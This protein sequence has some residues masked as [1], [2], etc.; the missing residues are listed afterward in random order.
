LLGAL[1]LAAAMPGFALADP[2][3]A[4]EGA[5]GFG[6]QTRGGDGG[7]VLYVT[8]LDDDAKKPARGSLRWAVEHDGPRIVRFKVAGNIRL[9]APL[10]VREP[11]LT[12][13]GS[14]APGPV[15][16][17]DYGLSLGDTHDVIVR[18]L[19]LRRGDRATLKDVKAKGLDRPK[20]SAGLDTASA[21]R[22]RNILFDHCSLSWSCDEVFGIVGC[23][24]VTIQWCIISGP[25]SNPRLHPYGDN[26]AFGLNLSANTLSL[27]H[28]LIAHYVMRGPQFEC[29]DVRK[30]QGYDVRMEAVNNVMFDYERSGS[31]YTTGIENNPEDAE[32]T[33]FEF[34]FINNYYV[35]G[36]AKKPMIEAVTRHGVIDDLRVYI[37]GNIG[38]QRKTDDLDQLRGVYIDKDTTID[39][40]DRAIR[41]QLV[42]RP[43]FA[44][45]VPVTI[46]PAATAYE[47][48]LA[49]AGCGGERDAVDARVLED[50]AKRRFGRIV[51]SQDDVG[52]WPEAK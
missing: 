49:E 36:D 22:S 10:E 30:G 44:A 35:N 50:V 17:R 39:R 19:R 40:A 51:K 25:L 45:P 13:D 24:N 2:K 32:G 41:E 48:V 52:G 14:D 23:Q 11:F 7:K 21:N 47:R 4:F 18:H 12:L 16:L 37:A 15:C 26:H 3:S 27:H 9:K 6:A 31:R 1:L 34:Q 38:P 33:K 46:E 28:C 8:T 42:D 29:N 43:L 5:E 20:G